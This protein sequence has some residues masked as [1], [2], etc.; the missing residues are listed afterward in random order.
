MLSTP[1]W[2]RKGGR[3]ASGNKNHRPA[4]MLFLF[5][6]VFFLSLWPG[7]CLASFFASLLIAVFVHCRSRGWPNDVIWTDVTRVRVYDYIWGIESVR[8][9]LGPEIRQSYEE[10]RARYVIHPPQSIESG[11]FYGV[12]TVSSEVHWCLA[13]ETVANYP[14]SLCHNRSPGRVLSQK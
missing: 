5:L 13:G 12:A 1:W 11:E 2:R 4:V 6:P 10:P 9:A 7:N 14:E 3:Y 8:D